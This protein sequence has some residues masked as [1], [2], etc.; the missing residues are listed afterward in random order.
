MAV[1][2][3]VLASG[4]RGNATLIRS[5]GAGLLLDVGLGPRALAER[6]ASLGAS[7][8]GIAAAVLTHTHGDHVDS[9][10]LNTLARHGIAF[11]SHEGHRPA[12][13]A[14]PGFKALEAAGLSRT[15][16]DRPFL[17]PNGVWVEPLPL[18]HDGP[19]FGFR[20]EA[21]PEKCRNTVAI[22]YLADSGSWSSAMA[23]AFAEVDVLGVEF[24]HDVELQRMS[25]RSQALISRNLGDRGHLS[26][27]Q[28]AEFVAAVL[29][30][31]A[32]S[33]VKHLVL[34]HLS[35]E[36]NTSE[37]ALKS[38]R[39]AVRQAGRRVTIH[40]ALQVL[41][42]PNLWIGPRSS[43]QARPRR[44]SQAAPAEPMLLF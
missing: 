23:D 33:R 6:L 3:A 10:T 4:S 26:N 36:C 35:Q 1:Q 28:G 2:F 11:Y 8:Q 17:A 30:R 13:G 25:Q 39:E 12:L 18:R 19:T 7:W 15:Y 27:R 5:G 41:P 32:R 38:A 40:A 9:G 37:L 43:T 24:N 29:D 34:L 20:L 22:G 16:D 21:R 44:P 14:M 42:H 31:S